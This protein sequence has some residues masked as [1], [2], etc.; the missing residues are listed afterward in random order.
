MAVTVAL[1]FG[2][3]PQL[4]LP[5]PAEAQVLGVDLYDL[6]R[7]LLR[8]RRPRATATATGG[9][10]LS[11]DAPRGKARRG[12][13]RIVEERGAGLVAVLWISMRGEAI[14]PHT[15]WVQADNHPKRE[16]RIVR[17]DTEPNKRRGE[18]VVGV[19]SAD[20]LGELA[21]ALTIEVVVKGWDDDFRAVLDGKAIA[22]IKALRDRLHESIEEG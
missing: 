21:N 6:V 2:V 10:K 22:Q 12:E 1:L 15:F 17:H 16:L 4:A 8:N 13:L 3:P 14:V 19:L 9:L 7:S 11:E 5:G 18:A 20:A